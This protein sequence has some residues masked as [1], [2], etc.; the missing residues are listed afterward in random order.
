M[1]LHFE[2]MG[3]LDHRV[4]RVREIEPDPRAERSFVALRG[5]LEHPDAVGPEL[6]LLENGNVALGS[7]K[8]DIFVEDFGENGRVVE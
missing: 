3:H 6:H 2:P 4:D 8:V 7:Q 1:E 5:D